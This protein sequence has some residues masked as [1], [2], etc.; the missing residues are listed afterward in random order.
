[1]TDIFDG[2]HYHELLKKEVTI[3]GHGVGHTYF[4][5][6]RDIALGLA[7]DGISPWRHRKATF[8]PILLYN[9]NLP[10]DECF[11]DDN[12]ICIGK[13]PGPTKPKDMDSFLYPAVQE[14]LKLAIGVQAYDVIDEEIFVLHAYL[15][16]IF[17]DIPAVSMLLR[18][19][20]QNGRSPCRLCMI[21]GTRI[22]N[23]RVTTH[24]LPL[25]QKNLQAARVDYDPTDLPMRTHKE[26]MEQARKVQLAETNAESER[27]STEYGINGVPLLSVL[28]SLSLPLSTGY[29]FMHLMFENTIP[30]LALLWSGNFKGLDTNQPFVFSKTVWD[31]IGA[32]TAATQSTMP[33]SYGAAVPNIVADRS[34]FTAETWSQ[35]ALF[36]GPVVL[37]GRF[38]N[39]Q[40]YNHF[41]ELVKLIKLC[42]KFEL[43]KEEI[44]T[45]R[46]GFI[47]W[48]KKYE[49]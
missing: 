48:V 42:L 27:L 37:N 35:W 22:P 19:K 12:M 17:G 44:A 39:K 25:C 20:G 23:S 36:V 24:Y 7:S 14:L 45:I 29:E 30:N 31:A 41:C 15:I 16:T 46:N 4:S 18:M 26:F 33:S 6:D 38:S 2:S 49:E 13:V 43:S 40:Y 1:M 8:W 11:H 5:D 10:P 32:T 28:D 9:F 34:S 3:N 47:R 21:Q